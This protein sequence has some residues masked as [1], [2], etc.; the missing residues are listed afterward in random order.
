MLNSEATQPCITLDLWSAKNGTSIIGVTGHW[1]NDKWEL[2]R[3]ALDISELSSPHTGQK[4]ADAVRAV[5]E[6]WNISSVVATVHDR[7]SNVKNATDRLGN[8][9]EWVCTFYCI[10]SLCL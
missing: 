1:I 10:I 4:I 8:L 3:I 9:T 6:K 7:G 2:K 5:L